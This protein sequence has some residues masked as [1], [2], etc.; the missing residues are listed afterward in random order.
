MW[1]KGLIVFLLSCAV[2]CSASHHH[3]SVGWSVIVAISD[4]THLLFG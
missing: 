3:G 2:K 1:S 4:H